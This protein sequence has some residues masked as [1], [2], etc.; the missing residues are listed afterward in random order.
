[1]LL[2]HNK[3]PETKENNS[4]Y[5]ILLSLIAKRLLNSATA[6]AA[7]L[8][9]AILSLSPTVFGFAAHATHFVI[10]FTLAGTLLLLSCLEKD[11]LLLFGVSGLLFGLAFL[12][13]QPAIFFVLF[14]GYAILHAGLMPW[15]AG[16][17]ALA[18]RLMIFSLGAA[19]P[20]ILVLAAAWLSSG[21]DKFWF[22]TFKYATD[23]AGFRPLFD[24]IMTFQFNFFKVVR[25]FE[26]L[27]IIGLFGL[28]CLFI[29]KRYKQIRWFILSFSFLS[30]FA[31][32]PGFHFRHHYF[33]LLLPAV[34]LLI[35]IP[36]NSI[37]YYLSQK[38]NNKM[39]RYF[40]FALF[41]LA[42]GLGINTHKNYFFIENTEALCRSI[43]EGNPFVES[44][45]IA[46]FIKSKTGPEDKIAVL[47]SEP[48]IF[49]IPKGEPPPDTYTLMD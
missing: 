31:V 5:L 45:K 47:G 21:F 33:I 40:P 15:P 35:G 27:W 42:I 1:M 6:L 41:L 46:E 2:N 8:S 44:L 26:I 10:L 32:C 49:F 4:L 17:K 43:Y 18:A 12:M 38:N 22:W 37:L 20:L 19:A 16:R 11:K 30:F 14:G 29:D 48:Q 36:F 7:S 39:F 28:L 23:Y 3:Q 25:G 9:Y 13:K 34:S 24:I